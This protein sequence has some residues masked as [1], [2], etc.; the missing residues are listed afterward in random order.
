[1]RRFNL[2]NLCDVKVKERYRLKILNAFA[3]LENMIINDL[4]IS[5]AWDNI[6][7]RTLQPQ[8]GGWRR[9]HDKELHNL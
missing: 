8:R 6:R 5:T 2:K 7:L 4:D 9:L 3:A 1:M